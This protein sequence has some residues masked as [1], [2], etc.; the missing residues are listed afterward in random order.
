MSERRPLT[1]AISQINNGFSQQYYLPYSAAMLEAYVQHKATDPARYRFLVP[2]YKRQPIHKIVAHMD[3][4]D[5]VGF[6]VYVWNINMSLE[7]ARRLKETRP[8]RL[9]IFGGPHV[10]DDTKAFLERHPFIDIAVHGE[11][12]QTFLEILEALPGRDFSAIAGLSQRAADGTLITTARRPRLRDLADLPSPFLSG[13]FDGVMNG[14]TDAAWIGLWETNR[15]CPFRC[16]Y[17]DWGSAIAAKVT[18]FELQRLK[19]EVDWFSK[20]GIEFIFCCDANFGILPRDVELAAY[21]AQVK[22]ATGFPVALSVQNTK[23][24]T[25]RAYETQKILSDAGLSKGVALSMQST[26]LGAL[27]NIK[28]ENISL[29]SYF[30]LQRRF[31]EDRVETFSD[32][33]LALPGETYDSYLNGIDQLIES[34]Q[35]NRIQFNNLSILPNAEMA[36]PAYRAR[37]GILT[38]HNEIIN[39]HGTRESFDDDIA[40]TQETVIGTATLPLED[41]RRAR[42][43]SWMTAFL[44]FDKL[45][46]IPL[47]TARVHAGIAYGEMFEAFMAADP[48]RFPTLSNMA[49]FFLDEADVIQR[50]GPEFHYSPDWLGIYWPADE[51]MF[52]RLSAENRL[53]AFYDEAEVLLADLMGQAGAEAHLPVLADAVRLNRALLKQPFVGTD[54]SIETAHDIL[55]F[56]EA[57]RRGQSAKAEPVPTVT[58]VRRSHQVWHDFNHWAREVV[59]WGNKKGAYLYTGAAVEKQLAGHF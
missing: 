28:R 27:E 4:A 56:Y 14:E 49:R 43:L 21:V 25:E 29:E 44:H 6:S 57:C 19:A 22:R 8:D 10:P 36:D 2:I 33:I 23:N 37:H 58:Q 39:I 1:V 20:H 47:M 11:G 32:L 59:W 54:L 26:N 52:L 46:Q 15:G 16:T 5:V 9:V 12:E 13:T 55:G 35:H 30:E 50:G 41:W 18:K 17:C 53:D 51:F 38:V 45:L 24:A 31:T 42:A 34:G 3:P 7:A 40:E 48:T